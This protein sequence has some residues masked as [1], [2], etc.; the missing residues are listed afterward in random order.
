M[1]PQNQTTSEVLG[2]RKH[3]LSTTKLQ[4]LSHSLGL[5]LPST[6]LRLENSG[7]PSGLH[8]YSIHCPSDKSLSCNPRPVKVIP[9]WLLLFFI[10]KGQNL[11]KA[12]LPYNLSWKQSQ[13]GSCSG[14]K[15]QGHPMQRGITHTASGSM[16]PKMVCILITTVMT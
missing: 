5:G 4:E 3:T 1:D 12:T 15:L 6:V 13:P 14:C 8:T 2:T 9:P 10:L 11:I 16:L 7:Y